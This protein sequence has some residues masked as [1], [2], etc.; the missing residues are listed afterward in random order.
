VTAAQWIELGVGLFGLARDLVALAGAEAPRRLEV[1]RDLD[2]ELA[3][4][5][6]R[7]EERARSEPT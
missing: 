4:I 1:V 5:R 3:A 6:K 7:R 2:P